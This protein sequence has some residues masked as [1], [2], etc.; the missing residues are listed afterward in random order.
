MRWVGKGNRHRFALWCSVAACALSIAACGG[1]GGGGGDNA[2]ATALSPATVSTTLDVYPARTTADPINLVADG[3]VPLHQGDTWAYDDTVDGS[4]TVGGL[5]RAVL[6]GPDG[7]GQVAIQEQEDT[8]VSTEHHVV[9]ADGITQIDPFDA[10]TA[11]PGIARDLPSWLMFANAP[12]R[13]A[14]T[15]TADRAG[16]A[17]IDL[18]GDNQND[19]YRLHVVQTF[20]GLKT[21]SVLGQ[22]T[23]V[24]HLLTQY[25]VEFR[26]SAD[27]STR[28]VTVT[29][30]E[31]YAPGLGLVQ[32]DRIVNSSDEGVVAL[33][34]LNLRA[35]HVNGVDHSVSSAQLSQTTIAQ[36]LPTLGGIAN[37]AY[38]A[39]LTLTLS[40]PAPYIQV[41]HTDTDQGIDSVSA[42]AL[43][44][45]H[46]QVDVAFKSGIALGQGSFHDTVLITACVDRACQIP[47]SGSPFSVPTTAIVG[48]TQMAEVGVAP[49]VPLSQQRLTHDVVAAR[50]NPA[51]G[52]LVM[53]SSAP[54][55][56]LYLLN[57]AT[58][59]E[60]SL[61]LTRVPT[62]LA[63]SPDGSEAAVGHAGRVTWV[64]LATVGQA[65]PDV[66][67][68]DLSATAFDLALDGMRHV[69]V[70]PASQQWDALHTLDVATHTETLSTAIDVQT[71]A[72][73]FQGNSRITLRPDGTALYTLDTMSNALPLK[74]WTLNAGVP[75]YVAPPTLAIT[76][77]LCDGLWWAHDGQRLLTACGLVLNSAPGSNADLHELGTL[78]LTHQGGASTAYRLR[79]A[80]Q[81]PDNGD[82]A[83]LE[84]AWMDCSIAAQSNGGGCFHHLN[85][86]AD[87]GFTLKSKLA[88]GPVAVAGLAYD[89]EGVAVFH[90]AD[91][92]HTYLITH[93]ARMATAMSAY[94]FQVVR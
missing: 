31:G 84:Y 73:F 13:M 72:N 48:Q 70:A 27:H 8:D 30:S 7:A 91:G 9:A 52:R 54:D 55:N 83:V 65:Q 75:S 56:R 69:H 50:Y 85:V 79:D 42:T 89:Q 49:L 46:T 57:P 61:P 3:Y 53:V 33:Q 71:G 16:D 47:V 76:G 26:Y 59:Q 25:V 18:D 41:S 78:P 12:L 68:L 44:S 45:L 51:L 11:L 2:P 28:T 60:T 58:G 32:T 40:Q 23:E 86:Y 67:L 87:E 92:Q 21:I 80:Q 29:L 5:T 90:S 4:T 22:P 37:D 93:L 6:S 77:S 17:G 62:A 15:R 81:R 43:D 38:V 39:H 36:I 66:R 94:L 1:G 63:L 19:S 24:A 35:A 82:W 10:V 14:D 88:L 74:P 64:A 20:K 34:V